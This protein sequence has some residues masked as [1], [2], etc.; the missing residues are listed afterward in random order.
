MN[1]ENPT[2]LTLHPNLLTF[3]DRVIIPAL[4]E[5]WLRG[6]AGADGPTPTRVRPAA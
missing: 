4:M 6:Q 5:R 1:R 3:L 2:A